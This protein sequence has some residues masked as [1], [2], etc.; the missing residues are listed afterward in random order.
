[1][2]FKENCEDIRNSKAIELFNCLQSYGSMVHIT[3]PLL[4]SLNPPERIQGISDFLVDL[5]TVKKYHYG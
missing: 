1:M 5:E 4:D 2:T 3:D